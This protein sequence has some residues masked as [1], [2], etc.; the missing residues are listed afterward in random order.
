[1]KKEIREMYKRTIFDLTKKQESTD[2]SKW[3][4][5]WRKVFYKVYS[6]FPNVSLEENNETTTPLE[7]LL[8]SRKTTR[9]FSDSSL[10]FKDVSRLLLSTM[11]ISDSGEDVDFARRTYPS[12]GARYP[13]EAYLISNRV[14]K[15]NKGLYHFN[16]RD[17][18]LE[19]MLNRDLIMESVEIAGNEMG[20]APLLVFLT[21]V[22]ART[23]VKYGTNAYRFVLI[24]AGHVGQNISLFCEQENWGSCAL[25]GFDN[26]K[27]SKLID[28]GSEEIPLYAFAIG[29]KKNGN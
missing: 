23:E 8:S 2:P 27:L 15:L 17:S 5:A 24:E 16:V 20:S 19:A 18:C 6:R 1:M 7:N 22:M 26:L 25:G 4:L 21:G 12:A 29:K 9:E 3:P 13:L 14:V 10:E 11:G 28:L